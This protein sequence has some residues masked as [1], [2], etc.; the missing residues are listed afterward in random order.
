MKTL[1]VVT[2]LA[3]LLAG[4]ADMK[5]PIALNTTTSSN[6]TGFKINTA[7]G[8]PGETDMAATTASASIDLKG[9]LSCKTK[10]AYLDPDELRESLGKSTDVAKRF[11]DQYGQ[12]IFVM[13]PGFT[14]SSLPI[15]YIAV[16]GNT[17]SD[18]GGHVLAYTDK[19][20]SAVR[21]ALGITNQKEHPGLFT[22]V[23]SDKV[24][25]A[26]GKRMT[27]FGCMMGGLDE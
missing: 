2:A 8:G 20:T 13:K 10:V 19:P 27:A 4:C 26:G 15:T 1:F 25:F 24:D 12:T 6:S 21:K 16:Y 9:T 18:A 23:S 11:R 14:V 5:L 7:V 22:Y 3:A 17:E